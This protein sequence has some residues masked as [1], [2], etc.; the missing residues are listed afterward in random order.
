MLKFRASMIGRLMAYPDKD[1]L[2][3]GAISA[4]HEKASQIIL[5]WQPKLD[6]HVIE[7]GRV[8]E[9]EAIALL[10]RV[11]GK[12]Y[13][14]NS[15]RLNTDLI[16]GEWDVYDEEEN[17]IIDIK[18][19]YSKKTFPIIISEGDLKLYEW[20]LTA[21]MHLKDADKAAIAYCLV[22]TPSDLVSLRD[23]EDWHIVSHIPERDRVTIFDMERC[24]TKERQMLKKVK[25]AQDE[26]KRILDD[27][28]FDLDR[29][30]V[31]F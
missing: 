20:Q 15:Q 12:S 30:K 21:Y 3:A 16:T 19:A 1:T 13:K 9:D 11:L 22:D 24:A 14:K 7:K 28:G 2:S 17:K 4:V 5:D 23:D 26:L 6:M 29:Y 27:R 18:N 10:N 25:L 8:C 31:D